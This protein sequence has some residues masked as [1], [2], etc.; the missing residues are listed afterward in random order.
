MRLNT[1]RPFTI[2][3]A[4]ILSCLALVLPAHGE[5][6]IRSETLL[7]ATTRGF[8]SLLSMEM[9]KQRWESTQLGRLAADPVMKPFIDDFQRQIRARLDETGFQLGLTWDDVRS[10][11]GGEVSL[12][13][14]Q[15]G[16]DAEAHAVV[17]IVD[18]SGHETEAQELIRKITANLKAREATVSTEERAGMELQRFLLP[19]KRGASQA[20]TV[21][22]FQAFDRLVLGDHQQVVES[23]ADRLAASQQPDAPSATDTL[24]T[25]P[26]FRAVM[27]RCR[28]EGKTE[29]RA[30]LRWFLE[31]FGYA[32]VARAAQGGSRR[33]RK[34]RLKLLSE[35]GFDALQGVGGLIY[36]A[37]DGHE[38][39]H[40]TFVH[41]PSNDTPERFRLAARMLD[42]PNSQEIT[43]PVPW[44][45]NDLA[46]HITFHW[47][48][49][50]AFDHSESLIDAFAGEEGFFK[51]LMTSLK[52]D[53]D[54]PQLDVRD[55]LV[56]H[57]GNR[58]TV[59]ADHALP[60]TTDSERILVALE[61]AE[62]DPVR[63]SV[64]RALA[65]DPLARRI[66]HNG[67]VI[68]E[69]VPEE[70]EDFQLS[71]SGPGGNFGNAP[72]T[73]E[74][75][76]PDSL[77]SNSAVTIFQ[78]HLMFATSIDILKKTL[79]LNA[80]PAALSDADDYHR[81]H[82]QLTKLG[83]QE[84][85][86]WMFSRQDRAIEPSYELLKQGKM[87]EA[88]T[89]LG[90]ILNRLLAPEEKGA[91]REQKI[92]ASQL[93]EFAHVA[94]YFGIGGLYVRTEEDGWYVGG[95][96]LARETTPV[97]SKTKHHN[98]TAL[99]SGS[100]AEEETR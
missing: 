65:T 21:V 81:M 49:K 82:E 98:R 9:S 46:T 88:R 73:E 39:Q 7:P 71:I 22:V 47:N 51:D 31:P 5:Q 90:R 35:Q 85:S 18:C 16:G 76:T 6:P 62:I 94:P 61:L 83:A 41:A 80:K 34:D 52:E 67:H 20:K 43:K 8:V 56:A 89:V 44:I 91:K 23:I 28:P 58:V 12:A 10:I 3:T 60:I 25:L 64:D 63:K 79:D 50:S 11:D 13:M 55:E 77:L 33:R 100:A 84:D 36:C 87:P 75:E 97:T 78:G 93:P 26:S 74:P 95:L 1:T 92:D 2:V 45:P 38:I 19:K 32:Q 30:D 24:S 68:W 14:T 48:M 72:T 40:H 96:I 42:F 15:P 66:E 54:G 29:S 53:E 4:L 17:L 99:I 57:L 59:I 70:E 86:L 69:F 27:E 37:T